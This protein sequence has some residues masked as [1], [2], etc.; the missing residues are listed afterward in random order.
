MKTNTAVRR[1]IA[2]YG[3]AI[4]RTPHDTDRI[5]RLKADYLVEQL[6]VAIKDVAAQNTLTPEHR[7]RLSYVALGGH[8]D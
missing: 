6:V 3:D 8:D 2:K 5:N 7:Q 4:R 1:K